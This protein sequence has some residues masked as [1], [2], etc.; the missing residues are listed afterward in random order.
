MTILCD[1]V[2]ENGILRPLTPPALREGET[3][4]IL[5][6][7]QREATIS[8]TESESAAAAL[9]RIAALPLEGNDDTGFSG[10]D[11]DRV[12]YGEPNSP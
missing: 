2:Y 7:P 8:R 9:A 6:V 11:H 3:V 1:A 10:S 4:E 5:L 12:L